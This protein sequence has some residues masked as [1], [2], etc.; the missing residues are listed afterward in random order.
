MRPDATYASDSP[1]DPLRQN[2]VPASQHR[3]TRRLTPSI[4]VRP[5][6]PI[7]SEP[8]RNEGLAEQRI[9]RSLQKA[10]PPATAWCIS[11]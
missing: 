11:S 7:P 2:T 5:E 10:P 8:S 6:N 4:C 9:G 3:S 1:P